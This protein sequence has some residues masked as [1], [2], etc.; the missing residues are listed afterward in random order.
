MLQLPHFHDVCSLR[1]HRM[2]QDALSLI[3]ASIFIVAFFRL[4]TAVS[5]GW[6]SLHSHGG[7]HAMQLLQASRFVAFQLW[8]SSRPILLP[9]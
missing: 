9:L 2:R 8:R 5:A 3:F 1:L 7:L 4:K 6:G